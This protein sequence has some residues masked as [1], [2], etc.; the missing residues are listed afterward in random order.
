MR[1]TPYVQVDLDVVDVITTTASVSLEPVA[2]PA[3]TGNDSSYSLRY[4]G[5]PSASST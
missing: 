1:V 2:T 3:T 4:P 5:V